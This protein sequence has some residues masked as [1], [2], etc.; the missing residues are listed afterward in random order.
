MLSENDKDEG[1]DTG[2]DSEDGGKSLRVPAGE[3]SGVNVAG[4]RAMVAVQRTNRPCA[5][6][7][8]FPM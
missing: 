6:R 5:F 2:L 7:L 8:R 1:L 4:W 3:P